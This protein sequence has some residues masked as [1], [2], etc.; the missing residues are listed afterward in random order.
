MLKSNRIMYLLLALTML[1]AVLGLNSVSAASEDYTCNMTQDAE[2]VSMDDYHD[3]YDEIKEEKL[4]EKDTK[5]NTKGDSELEEISLSMEDVEVNYGDIAEFNVITNPG[6]NEGVLALYIQ[7]HIVGL[8]DLS[9]SSASISINTINYRPGNYTVNATYSGSLIHETTSTT[10]TLTINPADTYV[11][12]ITSRFNENNDIDVTLNVMGGNSVVFYGTLNVYCNGELIQSVEIEED[13]VN[14]TIDKKYN[15]EI[16]VIEYVGDQYYLSSNTSHLFSLAKYHTNMYMPYPNGYYGVNITQPVTFY[17]NRPIN[18]GILD[19]YVDGDLMDEYNVSS[20]NIDVNFDLSEYSP[21]TYNV[22]L[23]YYGSDVY[24]D[25]S[26]TTTLTVRQIT[27]T[28]YTYNITG[29]KNDSVNLRAGVYNYVDET[30]EGMIEFFLDNESI[31]TAW[32][33]GITANE[34]Y[35]IPDNIAYGQHELKVVYYGSNRYAGA[36]GYA[37]LNVVKYSNSLSVRNYTLDENGSVEINIRAYSYNTT[38]EGGRMDYYIDGVLL[39][40]VPVNGNITKI[41]LPDEYSGD[42]EYNLSVKYLDSDKFEDA[43][44]NTTINP[45]RY[46]T[47]TRLYTYT[48]TN[49]TLNITTYVYSTNYAN[50][51]EGIVEFYINETMI[52]TSNVVNN[53]ANIIH[54]MTQHPDKTYNITAIYNGSRVYRPSENSTSLNYTRNKKSVYIQSPSSINEKPGNPI[55]INVNLTD[56]ESNKLPISTYVNIT[57]LDNEYMV[58]AENGEINFTYTIP[59]NTIPGTYNVSIVSNPTEDYKDANRTIRLNIYKDSPYITSPNTIR[60]NKL[61]SILINATLNLNREVLEDDI[62]GL[63]KINNKTIHQGLFKNGEFQYQLV[64]NDRYTNENYNITIVSI[65]TNQYNRAEKEVIL[66]LNPRKTYITSHN[67][68]SKNGEQ[69][70]INATVYDSIT[71]TP[72]TGTNK[73]CIKINDVTLDNINITNGHILYTYTNDYS[74][75]DYNIKIIYGK[76]GIYDNSTWNGT[77]TVKSSKLQIATHNIQTNAYKTID[78]KAN[79]LSD[80]KLATG[81]IN[82]AIKINNKTIHEETITNGKLTYTYTL[83]DEVGAGTYNLTII[84]GDSRKYTSDTTTVNL[85]VNKNYKEIQ[86]SNITASTGQTIS[87]KAKLVNHD[88]TPVT[89]ETK[90]NIKISGHTI[91]DHNITD[92][93]IE[94]NYTL[95]T[96]YQAGT[97]D[98]LIQAGETSGYYHATTITTLKVE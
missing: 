31:K 17:T 57:I 23:D 47:T 30:N 48:N 80:N 39:G 25:T 34:A 81:P 90:I 50:I 91:T 3:S 22:Y 32:I 14:F 85:T 1:I 72:V 62:I 10:A 70:I 20:D 41:V 66:N 75:K 21:G 4:I 12:N 78:I 84:A 97:Y 36:T 29:H 92:G 19:V 56:Y 18:D 68:E 9:V 42:H 58:W 54:D 16:V 87:I 7:Q 94:Y 59:P 27:T 52:G 53:S 45:T 26:Y 60:A 64:L 65:E 37:V 79:I 51:N 88:G 69:I 95:P 33:S 28:L 89:K 93:N 6:V 49:N 24:E 67:I 82:T 15:N 35:I 40:S 73:A 2:Y 76:N 74:A 86:T 83:S 5:E 46:N 44:L 71:R 55:T 96:S 77:L 38:V 43:I 61:E 8:K 13:D 11:T 63:L 98:L